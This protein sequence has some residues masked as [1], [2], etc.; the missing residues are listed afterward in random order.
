MTRVPF[1]GDTC[2]GTYIC[3][4]RRGIVLRNL[5]ARIVSV[6]PLDGESVGHKVGIM[7]EGCE[8]VRYLLDWRLFERERGVR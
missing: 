3:W 5:E 2:R 8:G 4:R 7:A 1:V 6:G